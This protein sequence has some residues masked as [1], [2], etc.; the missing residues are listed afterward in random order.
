MPLLIIHT[1]TPEKHRLLANIGVNSRYLTVYWAFMQ[2]IDMIKV[3]K[4]PLS[5]RI[6]KYND[7]KGLA[8]A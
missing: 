8:S 3:L 2:V 6:I 7:I 4:P 5:L 1:K